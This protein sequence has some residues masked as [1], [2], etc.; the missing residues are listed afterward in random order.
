MPTTSARKRLAVKRSKVNRVSSHKKKTSSRLRTRSKWPRVGRGRVSRRRRVWSR[1]GGDSTSLEIFPIGAISQNVPNEA[2]VYKIEDNTDGTNQVPPQSENPL[3]KIRVKVNASTG[4]PEYENVDPTSLQR[5]EGLRLGYYSILSKENHQ[6][7][8]QDCQ[9]CKVPDC[10]TRGRAVGMYD[11]KRM[12][13]KNEYTQQRYDKDLKEIQMRLDN[14]QYANDDTGKKLLQFQYKN[15]Q[16]KMDENKERC[17]GYGDPSKWEMGTKYC[18]LRLISWGCGSKGNYATN[19][20]FIA[21][22]QYEARKWLM[23]ADVLNLSICHFLIIP[24][25]EPKKV[26]SEGFKDI[27]TLLTKSYAREALEEMTHFRNVVYSKIINI[28]ESSNY[29]RGKCTI[30]VSQNF[31]NNLSKFQTRFTVAAAET[32]TIDDVVMSGFN[33]PGSEDLVHMQ[34]IV[35]PWMWKGERAKWDDG[36]HF[37]TPRFIPL[38]TLLNAHLPLK[39]DLNRCVIPVNSQNNY[40]ASDSDLWCKLANSLDPQTFMQTVQSDIDS[41]RTQNNT[42]S[43]PAF[44]SESAWEGFGKI[45]ST[46][47]EGH[48]VQLL[49]ERGFIHP[50]NMFPE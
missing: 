23:F 25:I 50:S 2:G 44:I 8:L 21:T 6:A 11:C 47:G 29:T 48:P 42:E 7:C 28:T 24:C 32:K 10:P 20:R 34:N 17:P 26:D 39:L 13:I 3:S 4:K 43:M 14:N 31:N 40:N 49:C 19:P 16:L 37:A 38:T 18:D 46:E 22:A 1:R 27:A 12:F 9:N 36:L 41:K 45:N 15:L 30:R 5:L 35:M 33:M